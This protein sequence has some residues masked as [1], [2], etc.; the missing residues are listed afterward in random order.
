[1]LTHNPINTG[2]G[3]STVELTSGGALRERVHLL[4]EQSSQ[5]RKKMTT[6]ILVFGVLLFTL[7]IAFAHWVLLPLDQHFSCVLCQFQ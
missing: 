7:E 6:Q 3:I 2:Y 5:P 1:M 4:L